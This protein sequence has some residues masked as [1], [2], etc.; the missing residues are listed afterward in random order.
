VIQL[1]SNCLWGK[2]A[3]DAARDVFGSVAT[4][5]EMPASV[6][7]ED[8]DWF[9]LSLFLQKDLK[10]VVNVPLSQA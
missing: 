2:S 5:A 3:G 6:H 10:I 1:C 4:P 7:Q 8:A 9:L